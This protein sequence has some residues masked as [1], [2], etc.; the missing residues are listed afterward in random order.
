MFYQ[1]IDRRDKYLGEHGV[2]GYA[3]YRNEISEDCK[4]KCVYCD[5]PVDY[6]GGLSAM[7]LDH[8]RPHSIFDELKIDPFNL[9]LSC[10]SCNGKKS[11]DWPAG[12]DVSVTYVDEGGYIEPF[13]N[14]RSNFFC[15]NNSGN[16]S[17][18]K[19]PAGYMI[20]RLGLNRPFLNKLR[21]KMILITRLNDKIVSTRA[22][23]KET[24]ERSNTETQFILKEQLT[25]IDAF[26]TFLKT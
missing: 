1:S 24:Y 23:L 19:H 20:H 9:V 12:N 3:Q 21:L 25:L 4:G 15:V 10:R 16:I 17:A 11:N 6:L 18:L 7:E 5:M 14:L 26:E 8:F 2:Y 22:K 13:K